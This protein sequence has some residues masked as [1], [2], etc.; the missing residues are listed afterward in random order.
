M[1][2][3]GG[4]N[5]RIVHI[6]FWGGTGL[7]IVIAPIMMFFFSRSGDQIPILASQLSFSGDFLKEQYAAMGS[8]GDLNAYR[9]GQILDYGFML[10]YGCLLVSAPL[11][12]AT[13]NRSAVFNEKIPSI[14]AMMGGIATLCDVIENAFILLTLSSP[15]NFPSSWAIIHSSFALIKWI[16]IGLWIIGV[17]AFFVMIKVK[18][19]PPQPAS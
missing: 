17:G 2:Q 19:I 8:G 3:H 18:K 11:R 9:I 13:R 10:A 4:I 16:L 7:L 5:D 12:I 14:I 1:S 15:A 6:V